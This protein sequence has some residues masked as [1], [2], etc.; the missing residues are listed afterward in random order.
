MWVLSKLMAVSNF[1]SDQNDTCSWSTWIWKDDILKGTGRKIRFFFEGE[2]NF[3]ATP[4]LKISVNSK[5]SKRWWHTHTRVRA[6]IYTHACAHTHTMCAYHWY[7]VIS[8][9]QVQGKVFYNGKSIS[10]TPHY[11]CSYVSQHD[12]HHAEMTV[13]EIINFSSNLLGSNNE[14][15]MILFFLYFFGIIKSVLPIF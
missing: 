13:R 10:S 14:F 8:L 7:G 2:P 1:C 9:L 4:V 6:H 12:L 3:A 5:I 11:L 15:G